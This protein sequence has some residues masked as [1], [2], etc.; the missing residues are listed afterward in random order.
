MNA[1]RPDE[2]VL[3]NLHSVYVDQWDW[4]RVMSPEDRNLDYLKAVVRDIYA[5]IKE[6]EWELADNFPQLRPFLPGED[7]L[8]PHRGPVPRRFPALTPKEREREACR[9][10]GAVFI[11]GIGGALPDGKIHDGRAPGLRRLDHARP[12]TGHRGLN[13]D[14][15]VWNP[16]L[17]IPFE[18][19]SMGIRVDAADH[20]Q[21]TGD[22]RLPG[23]AASCPGT[24]CCW[25]ASCP[26]SIGGGIGQS[27]LCMLLMQRAHIGEVQVGLLAA[28]TSRTPAPRR[29]SRCC[30]QG[31][32]ICWHRTRAGVRLCGRFARAP[33]TTSSRDRRANP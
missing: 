6:T 32:V 23:A 15:F 4:E 27:R 30:N 18:L 12:S 8:R 17:E 26:Q 24:S 7:R 9:E 16:V 33:H 2:A 11:I 13:G 14:I 29:E 5:A 21:A 25:R 31:R 10:H 3:D 20:A 19:S 1:L 28:P 22:P